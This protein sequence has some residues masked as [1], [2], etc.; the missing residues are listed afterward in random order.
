[1]IVNKQD[2]DPAFYALARLLVFFSF[3]TNPTALHGT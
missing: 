1:M 3:Q 2:T